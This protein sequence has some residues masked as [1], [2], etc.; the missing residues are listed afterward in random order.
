MLRQ[1]DQ[2]A[3]EDLFERLRNVEGQ[4]GPRDADAEALI[5]QRLEENP[6]AAYYM[7]Q[8]VVVQEAAL[9]QAQARIEALESQRQRNHGGFLGGIFGSDRP[10]AQRQQAQRGPWDS[11]PDERRRGNE[12]GFL[13]GA[14][15]TA[16]GVT[17]GVLLG[18]A[19]AGMFSGE[20]NA[21]DTAAPSEQDPEDAGD[22]TG[23]DDWGGDDPDV[24]GDF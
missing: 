15:Q 24:G 16:L 9:R 1:E 20:A 4:G 23:G 2:Q 5:R 7:A 21:A 12:G 17:S 13:A 18:S 3:I 22:D 10:A 19:I 11:G 14:A 6:A 8:T